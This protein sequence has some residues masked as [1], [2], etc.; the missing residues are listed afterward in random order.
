MPI[1]FYFKG[2]KILF[3][4]SEERRTHVHAKGHAATVKIWL[5]PD[6]EIADKRGKINDSELAELL[7][8]VRSRKNECV[9][10]WREYHG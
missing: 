1:V 9:A 3:Y 8:E 6:V 5:E 4:S 10:R 2:F 7:K